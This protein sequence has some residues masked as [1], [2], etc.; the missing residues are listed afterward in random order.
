MIKL[1]SSGSGY[2]ERNKNVSSWRQKESWDCSDRLAPA[3]KRAQSPMVTYGNGW[4]L[5]HG[6]DHWMATSKWRTAKLDTGKSNAAFTS[7][8]DAELPA[9]PTR[10]GTHIKTTLI[11]PH[12]KPCMCYE[13]SAMRGCERSRIWLLCGH[14]T[15]RNDQDLTACRLIIIMIITIKTNA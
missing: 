5:R 12:N 6:W 7:I 9:S 1:S 15:V 11:H 8:S 10:L 14:D 13:I 3:T 2:D 4:M